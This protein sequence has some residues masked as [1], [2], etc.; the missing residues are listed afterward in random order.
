MTNCFLSFEVQIY[1]PFVI[2]FYVLACWTY[3]ILCFKRLGNPFIHAFTT[4]FSAFWSNTQLHFFKHI[5]LTFSVCYIRVLNSFILI[6]KLFIH[7]CY[8]FS[9]YV[10]HALVLIW[11]IVIIMC[12]LWL[13][14]SRCPINLVSIKVLSA[15]VRFASQWYLIGSS[16]ILNS[17]HESMHRSNFVGSAWSLIFLQSQYWRLTQM[18]EYGVFVFRQYLLLYS[19][20][21]QT[22]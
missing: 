17:A 16:L 15:S 18:H 2:Y 4:S 14:I 9:R 5:F 12:L 7:T 10:L 13:S 19:S 21:M 11:T 8:F 3:L 1:T 22:N 20:G 6:R